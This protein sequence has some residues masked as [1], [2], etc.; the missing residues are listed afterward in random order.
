MKYEQVFELVSQLERTLPVGDWRLHGVQVWPLVR[1]RLAFSAFDAAVGDGSVPQGAARRIAGRLVRMARA[2]GA[3]AGD[4]LRGA[5][6][7]VAAD[8]LIATD[9]ISTVRAEGCVFDTLGDPLRE[10]AQ[11]VGR[12]RVATWY[13]TYACPRPRRT[14]GT[15]L[16]WRLDATQAAG[17]LARRAPQPQE[18]L[19]GYADFLAQVRAAGLPDAAVA[20]ATMARLARRVALMSRRMEAWLRRARPRLVLINCYYSPEGAALVSA[21]R[22]LGILCADVQHGVQG[23][24]HIAYGRWSHVPPGGWEL[25][26][27]RFWCWSDAEVEAIEAWASR[28]A[29]RPHAAIAGGNPWLAMWQDGRWPLVEQSDR[30]MR[31]LAPPG[32]RAAV[33]TLQWGMA[34]EVFLRPVL[35]LAAQAG[36]GWSWILRLHPVM[37]ADAPR[38]EALV[39][40]LGL[41]G[42][43]VDDSTR[44][45][46]PGLLRRA[47]VHLTHNSSA[48]LEAAAM[49]VASVVGAADAGSVYPHLERTGDVRVV[50]GLQGAQALAAL[51]E[52]AD[53]RR[54]PDAS[55]SGSCERAMSTLLAQAAA[56]KRED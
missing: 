32:T 39:Q 55:A 22:R 46:L 40:S 8:V 17:L 56:R 7:G 30:A 54:D 24:Q 25:L 49:G 23:A 3:L 15:L 38:I 4:V 28:A 21:C 50:P 20:Q 45:A 13:L 51:A 18:A 5:R 6:P 41:R 33:V 31:E 19:A 44:F 2:S 53:R 47:D 16:Q 14:R 37:R 52:M 10:L 42:V 48:V 29:G 1:G 34:D 27:D 26:P 9:G 43:S 11:R 35:A 12:A 36:A